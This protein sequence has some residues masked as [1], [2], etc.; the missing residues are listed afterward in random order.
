[1]KTNKYL[2]ILTTLIWVSVSGAKEFRETIRKT[3]GF[4]QTSVERK[5]VVDNVNGS[6]NVSGYDGSDVQLVVRKKISARS[7]KKLAEAKRTIKLDIKERSDFI[8]LYVDAPYRNADGD[9]NH[10]GWG[11]YG[12]DAH[13]DFDIK[14]PRS[15]TV[16]LKTVNDGEISLE[17]VT[18]NF[19]LDNI[20]GG[21]EASGLS[22]SGRIYA[23][24][25]D[26]KIDFAKNPKEH[27]YFGSLNGEVEVTFQPGFSADLRIKTFNGD[28]FSDFEVDY[29]NARPAR[30]ELRGSRFIYKT[31]RAIG[32]RIGS[33][34]P[35][36]E[37]DGFNG[38]IYIAKAR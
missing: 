31:D 33:G 16:L 13:F 37:F 7:E 8:E 17:N 4:N 38:D 28:V 14:V 36:I 34:G 23:L 29:L 10:R 11:Y 19:E 22:G 1:M 35:E 24:N 27:C 2:I 9:I 32:A 18:G 21:I 25:G 30:K 5:L 26:V 3:L 12:Y 6:I 20:N 15:V